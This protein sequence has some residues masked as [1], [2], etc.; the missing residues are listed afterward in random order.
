LKSKGGQA[1]DKGGIKVYQ[2]EIFL[3]AGAE[4]GESPSKRSP[5]RGKKRVDVG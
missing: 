1:R 4:E 5:V 2:F 3:R